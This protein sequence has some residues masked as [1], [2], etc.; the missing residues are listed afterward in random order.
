MSK[1]IIITCALSGAGTFNQNNPAVPYTPQEFADAAEKAYKAG[2]AMIHI[3]SC[4]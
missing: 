2:A 1:R 3:F 4:L